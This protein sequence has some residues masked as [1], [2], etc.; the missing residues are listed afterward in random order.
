[1]LTAME[2]SSARNALVVDDGPVERLAGKAMLER[3][4]FSVLTAASGEE[5]LRLL[6]QQTTTLVLCDI[7]MP[8][9]G[10]LMLL[11][12]VRSKPRPP[13]FIMSSSHSDTEHAA[14]SLRC[15]AWGYLTKP[16]RFDTLRD[17][18]TKALAAHP[19]GTSPSQ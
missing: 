2:Q 16:L 5:A 9:M 11:E 15:G 14:A 3:M 4:G 17:T 19:A 13:L 1:M 10:G 6:E 8:G 7:S 18:V 12:T